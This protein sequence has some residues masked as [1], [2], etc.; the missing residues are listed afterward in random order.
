MWVTRAYGSQQHS[1]SNVNC[2]DIGNICKTK[3]IST[4]VKVHVLYNEGNAVV[5]IL[6][7]CLKHGL[8]SKWLDFNLSIFV[9]FKWDTYFYNVNIEVPVKCTLYIYIYIIYDKMWITQSFPCLLIH[10]IIYNCTWWLD[11]YAVLLEF[12]KPTVYHS[13][14]SYFF[15]YHL[16]IY[17]EW[18]NLKFRWTFEGYLNLSEPA[19][20]S[21][22]SF[23]KLEMN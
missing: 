1:F 4:M 10:V 23:L 18:H 16:G 3:Y 11:V 7:R 21:F 8:L 22:L 20:E 12:W 17:C 14:S 9:I 2:G 6:L 19:K 15:S 13:F 5:Y